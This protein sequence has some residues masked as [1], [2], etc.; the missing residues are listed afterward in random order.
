MKTASSSDHSI[1]IVIFLPSFMDPERAADSLMRSD[2]S[3]DT[4]QGVFDRDPPERTS[5]IQKT[6]PKNLTNQS[7]S[8]YVEAIDIVDWLQTGDPTQRFSL[9]LAFSAAI[10]GV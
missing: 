1:Q 2:I 8:M 9:H 7:T 4:N 5:M 10:F 3:R 6:A